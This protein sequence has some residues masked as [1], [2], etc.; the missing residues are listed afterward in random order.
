MKEY[1]NIKEVARLLQ[2]PT[3]T[4][5]YWDDEGVIHAERDG[6]NNYRKFSLSNII[7]LSM[8]SFYRNIGIPIRDL[9]QILKSERELQRNLLDQEE[10]R[11]ELQIQNMY[12]QQER[13][14]KQ[15]RLLQEVEKLNQK[16]I[17]KG[18]PAFQKVVAFERE[19]PRHWQYMV[20]EPE[21]FMLFLDGKCLENVEYAVGMNKE[22]NSENQ[23]VL[24]TRAEEEPYMEG[25][26]IVENQDEKNNNMAQL[27][28]VLQGKGNHPKVAIAQYLSSEWEKKGIDYY[29]VWFEAKN[30]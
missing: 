17:G 6:E 3:S 9:K 13:I 8:V 30:Q 14:R 22:E 7:E 18:K 24:W 20:E 11:I 28:E 15:K 23:Q 1:Y 2:I 5:R 4:L 10:K 25:L 26:L 21:R 16:T 19:N 29:K 27:L 12:R